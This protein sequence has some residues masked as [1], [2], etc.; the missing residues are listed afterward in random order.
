MTYR[1]PFLKVLVSATFSILVMSC[2]LFIC[3]G[4]VSFISGWLC[5]LSMSIYIIAFFIWL[6]FRHPNQ[7]KNRFIHEEHRNHQKHILSGTIITCCLSL[8]V[9]GL[10]YRFGNREAT[11]IR[12]IPAAL[13]LVSACIIHKTVLSENQFLFS[14]V[15]AKQDQKIVDYGIYSIV[16]HP[17]YLGN[18]C[19]F[20]SQMI[21]LNSIWNTISMIGMIWF[22]RERIIDE[23]T[24]LTTVFPEY[25]EYKNSVRYRLIPKIW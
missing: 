19:L 1:K 23:E 18:L 5:I 8:F 7:L 20:I 16:R 25:H 3:A 14:A 24:F 11:N 2:I 21:F 9:A 13:F 17:M 6:Y 4:T 15:E 22:I 10:D 12:L